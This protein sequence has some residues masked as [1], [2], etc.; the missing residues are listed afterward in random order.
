M[1]SCRVLLDVSVQLVLFIARL[2]AAHR[3]EIG[4][5]VLQ[6]HGDGPGI[7]EVGML[8]PNPDRSHTRVPDLSIGADKAEMPAR[9]LWPNSL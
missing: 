9:D 8:P 6:E 2:L 7:E 1:L 4:N 5:P 3:R